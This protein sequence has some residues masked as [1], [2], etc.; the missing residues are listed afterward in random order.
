[1]QRV[2]AFTIAAVML[3]ILADFPTTAGL[4]V[5]FAWLIFLSTL[6]LIGPVAFGRLQ[7]FIG[8]ATPAPTT[9]PTK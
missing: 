5:A 1:M 9:A 7:S 2:G 6:Y 8:A 3:V 4:A